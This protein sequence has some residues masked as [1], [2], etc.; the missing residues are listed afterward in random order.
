[1]KT[2]NKLV[3]FGIVLLFAAVGC[4]S[5]PRAIT[6][7]QG[8]QK[9]SEF[10]KKFDAGVKTIPD[11]IEKVNGL[12]AQLVEFGAANPDMPDSLKYLVDFR[13]KILEA[14][15]LH[16]AG[17]QWGRASTTEDGFGCKKG[18]A[19]IR[20]SARL[21]NSS[22]QKGYGAVNVLQLFIDKFPNEAADLNLTQKDVVFLNAAYYAVESK[23]KKDDSIVKS[24]CK[25]SI[26]EFNL[27]DIDITTIKI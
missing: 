4:V 8:I 15:K 11:S 20:A 19:I 10:D 17:W 6:F 24:L 25:N 16:N 9:I 21:R 13:I 2:L 3:I 27:T 1:M 26:G 23:A 14:E 18:Y 5:S 7:E 12:L 22:V